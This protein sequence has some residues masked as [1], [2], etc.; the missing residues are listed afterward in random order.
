MGKVE[1]RRL[2]T[3][4]ATPGPRKAKP[5]K[6]KRDNGKKKAKRMAAAALSA[7]ASAAAAA[8][9]YAVPL[10]IP[11]VYY[12]PAFLSRAEADAYYDLFSGS[13]I[14][15]ASSA[16]SRRPTAL[17]GNPTVQYHGP[18][19][20]D[21]LNLPAAKAEAWHLHTTGLAVEFAVCLLNKYGEADEMDPALGAPRTSPIASISLGATRRFGLRLKSDVDSPLPPLHLAHGS[22]TV[23]E[24]AC[25]LLYHHS[26][27]PAE[28]PGV[29]INLT[30]RARTSPSGSAVG[31]KQRLHHPFETPFVSDPA[32]LGASRPPRP[33]FHAWVASQLQG[34]T[35]VGGTEK[36]KRAKDAAHVRRLM[37]GW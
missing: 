13:A 34:R 25:Q 5:K 24:N 28:A 30:F 29:R 36:K 15:W 35:L 18:R 19:R 33:L 12:D 1:E 27:L 22:L 8:L 31:F 10:P 6:K 7:E 4:P 26:V 17:Y 20:A 9:S 23:M 2:P 32:E 11:C 14:Q 21:S 37:Q 3:A 16:V